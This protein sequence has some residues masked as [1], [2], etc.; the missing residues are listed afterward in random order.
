[1]VGKESSEIISCDWS[2]VCVKSFLIQSERMRF[3]PFSTCV[4]SAPERTSPLLSRSRK[5]WRS[6]T[7]LSQMGLGGVVSPLLS[8]F[9]LRNKSLLGWVSQ[10]KAE[11][12]HLLSLSFPPCPVP[13]AEQSES[14]WEQSSHNVLQADIN[15]PFFQG[16]N[17][18][19]WDF[20]NGSRIS[21][22]FAIDRD[23]PDR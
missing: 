11:R 7:G 2:I 14:P 9:C 3:V 19:V 20:R 15:P 10:S 16:N 12:A 22:Q 17:M 21:Q 5:T 13:S 1:M 4:T 23:A 8:L 6:G 18:T